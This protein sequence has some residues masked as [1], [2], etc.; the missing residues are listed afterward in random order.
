MR[1]IIV[2]NSDFTIIGGG[3]IGATI[4]RKLSI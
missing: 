2:T 1:N 4:A 3:I